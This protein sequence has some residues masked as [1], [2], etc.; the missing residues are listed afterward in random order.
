LKDLPSCL[1]R[2]KFPSPSFFKLQ[3]ITSHMAWQVA[4]PALYFVS[5]Q[6]MGTLSAW[7]CSLQGK[8]KHHTS[9]VD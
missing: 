7:N 6:H 3:A 2:G 5:K 4:G 9:R 1:S 8:F